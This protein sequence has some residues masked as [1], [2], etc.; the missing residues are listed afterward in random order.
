MCLGVAMIG[1]LFG[2]VDGVPEEA[3]PEIDEEMI[4]ALGQVT[5]EEIRSHTAHARRCGPRFVLLAA[6][7]RKNLKQSRKNATRLEQ[8]HKMMFR[9]MLGGMML[10]GLLTFAGPDVSRRILM[11]L[12]E[13]F[14]GIS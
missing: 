1:W 2:R 8:Q 4:K 9:F 11:A 10:L 3:D 12:V 5:D 7:C 13:K 6:M 14:L